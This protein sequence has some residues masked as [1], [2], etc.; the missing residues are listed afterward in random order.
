MKEKCVCE[1]F[2]ELWAASSEDLQRL[3]YTLTC[4]DQCAMEE[5][6]ANVLKTSYYD[7][8]LMYDPHQW[9]KQIYEIVKREAGRFYSVNTSILNNL[10]EP[11]IDPELWSFCKLSDIYQACFRNGIITSGFINQLTIEEQQIILLVYYYDLSLKEISAIL[12][13]SCGIV[14]TI[15]FRGMYKLMR[16]CNVKEN[17]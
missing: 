11:E 8:C 5:I 10:D 16:L 13:I 7:L 17:L 6:F 14:K 12:H 1:K 3:I 15:H 2:M 4:K 9:V